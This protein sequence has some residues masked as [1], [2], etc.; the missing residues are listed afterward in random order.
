MLPFLCFSA[1]RSLLIPV[2]VC[3]ADR[4]CNGVSHVLVITFIMVI[5]VIFVMVVSRD[6]FLNVFVVP[7]ALAFAGVFALLSL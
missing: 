5:V 1:L 7:V 2:C 3:V 6:M 4:R